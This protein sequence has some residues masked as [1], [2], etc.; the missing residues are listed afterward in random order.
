MKCNCPDCQRRRVL[1]PLKNQA[2]NNQSYD[3]VVLDLLEEIG[4]VTTKLQ[5]VQ[6]Q[7]DE[8]KL[9]EQVKDEFVFKI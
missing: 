3:H 5:E 2:W 8:L 9:P 7:L 4:K 6:S 1:F